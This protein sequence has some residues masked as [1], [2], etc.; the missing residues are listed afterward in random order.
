MKKMLIVLLLFASLVGICHANPLA[1]SDA[2]QLK[3]KVDANQLI[4]KWN[5]APGYLLYRHSIAISALPP[6][7]LRLGPFQLPSG[8]KHHDVVLGD[9]QVYQHNLQLSVPLSKDEIGEF[10]VQANFQGCSSSGFCF[11]P[12][13]RLL[14]LQIS[15][16]GS[17]VQ[18]IDTVKVTASGETPSPKVHRSF[19][20]MLLSFFGLGILLSFTPCVLPMIPILS[21]IVIGKQRTTWQAFLLSLTYVLAMALAYALAGL[22]AGLLGTHIQAA[23]QQPWIIILFITLFVVLSLSLFGFYNV[24]LPRK[25][26]NKLTALNQKPKS[27]SYFGVAVMGALSILIV[28]PCISAP[29]VAALAYIAQSGHTALGGLLLFVMGLGM[30][31]PLILV[32]TFGAKYIPKSGIWMQ[33]TKIILGVLLLVTAIWLLY[34]IVPGY[35]CLIVWGILAIVSSACLGVFNFKGLN[36][37][38]IIWFFLLWLW[39]ALGV[40][41]LIGGLLG[42]RD[43]LHPLHS[44]QQQTLRFIKISTVNDLQQALQKAHGRYVMLDFYADWCVSCKIIEQNVFSQPD[45]QQRLHDFIILQANVSANNREDIALQKYLRVYA[46]PTIVFFNRQ[47]HEIPQTRIVGEISKQQFITRL[48][49]MK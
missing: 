19:L 36:R 31:V 26:Q 6:A 37:K 42:N 10:R 11:P 27:G 47:G 24:Q 12:Q 23:L 48:D 13:Q 14:T 9:Y 32:G 41:Y 40:V 35:I 15:Q 2:F 22:G 38:K 18:S 17:Q 3:A 43:P 21:S 4:L 8:E 45:V 20:I 44:T 16:F 7:R 34:R 30:G 5:I 28:S 46:P 1:P 49:F 39:F 29:L 33:K 25:W